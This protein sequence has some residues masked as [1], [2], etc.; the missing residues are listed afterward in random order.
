MEPKRSEESMRS[1]FIVRLDCSNSRLGLFHYIIGMFMMNPEI[2]LQPQIKS[3]TNSCTARR[4][5]SDE[6]TYKTSSKREGD[7]NDA[8]ID[9]REKLPSLADNIVMVPSFFTTF[10]KLFELIRNKSTF[11]NNFWRM[12]S[13]AEDTLQVPALILLSKFFNLNHVSYKFRCRIFHTNWPPQISNIW[14]S[15]SMQMS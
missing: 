10:A 11:R 8:S 5:Y 7:D 2:F 14:K 13:Q 6:G 15:T 9:N 12:M 4:W 1:N 3:L